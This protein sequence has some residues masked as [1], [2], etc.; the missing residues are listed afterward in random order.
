MK[1]EGTTHNTNNITTTLQH[2][3]ATS[4][5]GRQPT[6]KWKHKF[7]KTENQENKNKT[8]NGIHE[9]MTSTMMQQEASNITIDEQQPHLQKPWGH[10]L[11]GK[12]EGQIRLLLQNI[13]RIDMTNSGSIKLAAMRGFINQAGADI[14]AITKCNTAWTEAP[15]HL[16]QTEQTQYWWEN[17]H[18]SLGHNK[19]K[20]FDSPYQPGRT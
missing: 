11:V 16:Y 17:A 2:H 19:H 5:M 4:S 7:R 1:P 15:H 12:A 14:I 20:H 10:P 6:Y 18:W 9:E 3:A 13:G 8:G